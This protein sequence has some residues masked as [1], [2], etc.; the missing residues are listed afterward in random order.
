MDTRKDAFVK[1]GLGCVAAFAV[2]ALL[3]VISGG[4]AHFSVGG[5]IC[6]FAVG[7][8]VGLAVFAVYDKGRRDA[9]G[10]Q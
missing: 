7:G 9:A 2:L 4:S 3:A 10:Q 6:L 8:A 5:L 1:G